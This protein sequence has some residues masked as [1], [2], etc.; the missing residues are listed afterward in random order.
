MHTLHFRDLD[1]MGE[2]LGKY[3]YV[4]EYGDDGVDS[5]EEAGGVDY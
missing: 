1:G 3:F 5:E 4:D 2:E